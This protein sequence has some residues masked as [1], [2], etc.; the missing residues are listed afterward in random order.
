MYAVPEKQKHKLAHMLNALNC[1]ILFGRFVSITSRINYN[2]IVLCVHKYMLQ[3][4]TGNR[5]DFKI[6]LNNKKHSFNPNSNAQS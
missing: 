6:L 5:F 4:N 3:C 2:W 1:V